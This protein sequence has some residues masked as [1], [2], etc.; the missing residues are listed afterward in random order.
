MRHLSE[1]SRGERGVENRGGSRF[2]ALQKGG[3]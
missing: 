1:I 3:L 2:L